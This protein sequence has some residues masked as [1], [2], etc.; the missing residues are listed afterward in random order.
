MKAEIITI[1][2]EILL[3]QVVDTNSA[4]IGQQLDSLQIAVNQITSISDKQADI[5]MALK[6]ASKRADLIIVTGGLGPTKDDLTKA[7]IANYFGSSLVRDE[8]VLS[9]VRNIFA[10]K[11]KGEMPFA[12]Y[13]Q[14]DVLSCAD[15]LFNDVGTAPGMCIEY[16]DTIYIFLP[17]V[18]FEMKYLITNRVIPRLAQLRDA[19]HIYHAHVITVG[20]GES[21]LAEKIVDI[22]DSLPAYIKLAYLPKLGLVRMR[23]TATGTDE[24]K[25]IIETNQF[26]DAIAER[27]QEYVVA[28]KDVTI[29][30][31]I[32]ESFTA[33]NL[34]LAT[35]ESCTGGN[36]AARITSVAGA[37]SIFDCS[38]VAYSNTIKQ[39]LLGVQENTL[40]TEGAVSEQTVIQ[41]AE[42]VKKVSNADYAI[43]TSGIAGP[44]GGTVEKPV[45]TVWIA[46]A[47]KSKT[48]TRKF[49]FHN[50]RIVNIERSTMQALILLW[51]L[52]KE[53][54]AV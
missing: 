16:E 42:G 44:G 1:G 2:D 3:G 49:Q 45:G 6:S 13:A 4:W 15:V 18:P 26:A 35:A 38:I 39:Q 29:E 52:Y 37:S 27:M 33:Q 22:E 31:A 48:V 21:F 12:N 41:M 23:L 11:G 25:L 24:G 53:E 7:T 43:A 40:C 51:N 17:G 8:K 34:K 9:H 54:L 36:I 10:K 47:G 46:V 14:A 5:Y 50:D 28:K 20:I 19:V 32:V 30:E